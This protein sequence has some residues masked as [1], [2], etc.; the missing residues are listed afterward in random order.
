MTAKLGWKVT[1]GRAAT[2]LAGALVSM[3]TGSAAESVVWPTASVARAKRLWLP[4]LSAAPT[5]MLQAPEVPAVALPRRV[6]PS[7]S[8]TTAPASATPVKVGIL[9]LVRLSLLL[10]P[11]SLVLA[12]SGTDTAG[13]VVS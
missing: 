7:H 13:G 2:L 12:R 5:L 6:A 4:S 11:V 10:L 8:P 9:S 3:V 1:S